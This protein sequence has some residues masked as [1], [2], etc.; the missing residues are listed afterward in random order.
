MQDPLRFL[1]GYALR[2]ASSAMMAQLAE[3]LD[4]LGV[5]FVEAS[6]LMVIE[7][8]PG[9]SQ[10]RLCQLLDIKRANMT[11]LATRLE[12]RG[13]IARTRSDGRSFGLALSR[14]GAVL[15]GKVR[16][17]VTA[18]EEDLLARVPAAHRAHLLPALHAIWG[19]E[20]A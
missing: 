7:D 5:R 13:L 12:E 3:R 19:E 11:P 1:P 10:S 8:N 18:H 14:E 15:T 6:I 16:A 4:P 17:A 9:I 2:R 20:D